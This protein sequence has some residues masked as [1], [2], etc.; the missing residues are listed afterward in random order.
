MFEG[1]PAQ[2]STSL[3]R[4][5]AL[6]DDTQVC[7]TH[8]YT[9]SN[10]RFAAGGGARQR[11]SRRLHQALPLAAPA[12]QPT[13]PAHLARTPDQ[14]LSALHRTRRGGGGAGPGRHRHDTVSVFAALREW[15]NHF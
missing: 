8:E 9:L 10:L 11:R 6:P 12:D 1:T 4:L 13:L 7:C 15:K 14:P 2:M 3:A 5:A